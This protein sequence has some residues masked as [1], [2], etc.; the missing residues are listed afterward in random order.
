[1]LRRTRSVATSPSK[2]TS[3]KAS[4]LDPRILKELQEQV[5]EVKTQAFVQAVLYHHLRRRSLTR[6]DHDNTS[7]DKI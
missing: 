1:M 7:A 2:S 6:P 3:D 4:T 5:V